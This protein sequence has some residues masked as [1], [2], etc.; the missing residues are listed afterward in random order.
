MFVLLKKWHKLS[1]GIYE[2]SQFETNLPNI[3]Q[4]WVIMQFHSSEV[5]YDLDIFS[6]F[7][8][9]RNATIV[10]LSIKDFLLSLI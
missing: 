4:R 2:S 6:P 7:Y 3:P 8:L 9:F 1:Y 5:G 10:L